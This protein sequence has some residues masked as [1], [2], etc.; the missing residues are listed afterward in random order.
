MIYASHLIADNEMQEIIEQTGMGVESIDF[1]IADVLD[2]WEEHLPEGFSLAYLPSPGFVKL[3]LTAKGD[4]VFNLDAR[5]DS[6]KEVSR[7][8][9]RT[10]YAAWSVSGSESG[11]V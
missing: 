3:R 1:S 7:N 9:H 11:G 10:S 5:Y 6:L 4:Q 2:H 8:G